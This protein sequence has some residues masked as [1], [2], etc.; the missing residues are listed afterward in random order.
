MA[1]KV[2]KK[3]NGN[4]KEKRF[5][6]PKKRFDELIEKDRQWQLARRGNTHTIQ[7]SRADYHSTRYEPYTYEGMFENSE[8]RRHEQSL[9]GLKYAGG[10][11]SIE[12]GYNRRLE[13]EERMAQMQA[14]ERK[15]HIYDHNHNIDSNEHS[16]RTIRRKME[17]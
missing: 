6:I 2:K 7:G 1:N 4:E 12:R 5:K 10:E 9:F 8:E 11:S 16:E 3:K 14:V 13:H 17:L 15:H